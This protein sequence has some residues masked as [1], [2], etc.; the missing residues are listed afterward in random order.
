[1]HT[2]VYLLCIYIHETFKRDKVGRLMAPVFDLNLHWNGLLFRFLPSS[3]ITIDAVRFK[4]SLS[5]K[6]DATRL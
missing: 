4:L 2:Y 3:S 6:Y 1:M 5:Y